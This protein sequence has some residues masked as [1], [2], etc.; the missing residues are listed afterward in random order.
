MVSI[1]LAFRDTDPKKMNAIWHVIVM[2]ICNFKPL[3]KRSNL[4]I[5]FCQYEPTQG[6]LLVVVTE[7][8]VLAKHVLGGGDDVEY[9]S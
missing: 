4:S 3:P 2:A 8:M 1:K 5:L 9:E 7:S 6:Y